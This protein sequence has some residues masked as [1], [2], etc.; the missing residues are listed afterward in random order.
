MLNMAIK[1]IPFNERHNIQDTEW[2]A[3]ELQQMTEI[4]AKNETMYRNHLEESTQSKPTKLKQDSSAD[5]GMPVKVSTKSQSTNI[6]PKLQ[7]GEKESIQKW[8]DDILDI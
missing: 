3:E 2:R 8:L 1:S 7:T 4:A 5:T 6:E